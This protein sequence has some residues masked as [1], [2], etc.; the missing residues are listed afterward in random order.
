[1]SNY[2]NSNK[3]ANYSHNNNDHTPKKYL[4]CVTTKQHRIKT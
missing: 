3:S 4:F 2:K 1:M